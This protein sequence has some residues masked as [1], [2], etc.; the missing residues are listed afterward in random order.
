MPTKDGILDIG[1]AKV[2]IRIE[3][4]D[5]EFILV[6]VGQ[7]EP[8]PEPIGTSVEIATAPVIVASEGTIPLEVP[9]PASFS[10][11]PETLTWLDD[12]GER[13]AFVPNSVTYRW[14]L[15]GVE[16]ATGESFP[17]GDAGRI[18]QVLTMLVE[19]ADPRTGE[20]LRFA[21]AE[22]VGPITDVGA[23]TPPST[24]EPPA[25]A[26]L[27]FEDSFHVDGAG[28]PVITWN[29]DA[30][31]RWKP[32]VV[33]DKGYPILEAQWTTS[34]AATPE[35]IP[36]NHVERLSLL[37]SAG[38]RHVYTTDILNAASAG[39]E[40]F[41]NQR[42]LIDTPRATQFRVRIRTVAGG[43]WSAWS[44][45]QRTLAPPPPA[46]L[47][48][49]VTF[50]LA[51]A[52]A[53]G[54][55]RIFGVT[56][57]ADWGDDVAGHIEWHT[58]ATGWQTAPGTDFIVDLPSTLYGLDV[59]VSLR[60]VGGTGAI[61]PATTKTV[62]VPGEAA[63]A[64]ADWPP[65]MILSKAAKDNP[66]QYIYPGG[67]FHRQYFH[68]GKVSRKNPAHVA[69]V[70]DVASLWIMPDATAQNPQMFMPALRNVGVRNGVSVEW[71]P[72]TEGRLL[73]ASTDGGSGG[74][75]GL[76]L[77]ED[78]GHTGQQ[79]LNAPMPGGAYGIYEGRYRLWRNLICWSRF[80]TNRVLFITSANIANNAGAA[81]TGKVFRS[82]NRGIA[83][84]WS[85]VSTAPNGWGICYYLYEAANGDWIAC[86][87]N[88][89]YRST[90]HGATWTRIPNAGAAPGRFAWPGGRYTGLALSETNAEEAYVVSFGNG[91]YRT[92][93][94]FQTFDRR[95]LGNFCSVFASPLDF[96]SVWIT[97][98]N[99][100]ANGST[101]GGEP[102][103]YSEN[104][105]QS[106]SVITTDATANGWDEG[107][108]GYQ[109]RAVPGTMAN[110][111]EELMGG[112]IPL[113]SHRKDAI[114]HFA[115]K[116][117]KS[118][119]SGTHFEW[120]GLNAEN[121]G[122]GEANWGNLVFSRIDPDRMAIG[123]FDEGVFES[124]DAGRSF[125]EARRGSGGA[126]GNNG[127]QS[128]GYSTEDDNRLIFTFGDYTTR[129][130]PVL[131]TA[132]NNSWA[133]NSLFINDRTTIRENG[134]D[135]QVPRYTFASYSPCLHTPANGAGR[136]IA[137]NHFVSANNGGSW[138][139]VRGRP[140]WPGGGYNAQ[141]CLMSWTDADTI[142]AVNGTGSVLS[143]SVD[144]GQSWGDATGGGG[145]VSTG[146]NLGGVM[147]KAIWINPFDGDEVMWWRQGTGLVRYNFRTQSQ[148]IEFASIRNQGMDRIVMDASN[149]V[150]EVLYVWNRNNGGEQ[151]WR[152]VDGS[153]ENITGDLPR[154]DSARSIVCCPH[155]GILFSLGTKGTQYFA[156]PVINALCAERLQLYAGLFGNP[157]ALVA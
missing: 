18:G 9:Y 52:S 107:R 28:N 51:P 96:D 81:N 148:K 37:E 156:P 110:G 104:G 127:A 101:G 90:D 141:I 112:F 147:A 116:W 75:P 58:A 40:T 140:G 35:A 6:P 93:D 15:D 146:V 123:A 21:A 115:T 134:Q 128:G 125:V 157:R 138:T 80:N 143:R 76:Y 14:Y 33:I 10:V 153:V 74:G 50:S 100:N 79:V 149:P 44:D 29:P 78:F 151:I 62:T 84:S 13:V 22:A 86:A 69:M 27:G 85:Q 5:H 46:D 119:G 36:A 17:A 87:Q 34:G 16:I 38:T 23:S 19:V 103:R 97:A 150:N 71:D 108:D 49:A 139:D 47:P 7:D 89:L 120:A 154:Q 95:I 54:Q 152:S 98:M 1:G 136:K 53:D 43:V 126:G 24:P 12:E 48:A 67:G 109:L 72:T 102:S 77:S 68:G 142:Y 39:Y 131:R 92:T 61:G 111:K 124:R 4:A 155:T 42:D 129:T 132:G 30:L 59:D 57:P 56:G 114:C 133:T 91:V 45:P 8:G 106:S 32:R 65:F 2:I 82:N 31:S 83:G 70:M 20:I 26:E 130:T 41:Y 64:T 117:F 3:G 88:G 137:T 66:G 60:A 118:N 122:S 55:V 99:R 94:G 113:Q 25:G 135:V 73:L 121:M 144:F 105:L 63:V 11:I 145:Q